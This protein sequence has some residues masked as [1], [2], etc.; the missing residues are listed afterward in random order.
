M[1]R[2]TDFL[3]NRSMSELYDTYWVPAC[4]LDYAKKMAEHVAPGQRVL[5]LGCGTGVVT[6]YATAIAGP[7][8]EVTGYDPTPDL[9][10]AAR[11]KSF[12]GAPIKWI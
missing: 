2:L 3:N 6:G 12:S 7:N 8:G 4:L 10:N 1:T 11:Q 5:D 9:L